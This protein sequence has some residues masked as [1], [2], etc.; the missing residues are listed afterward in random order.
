M[1]WQ[2]VAEDRKRRS[3]NTAFIVIYLDK[4]IIQNNKYSWKKIKVDKS[5][6]F[7]TLSAFISSEVI[8]VSTSLYMYYFCI[9]T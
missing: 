1:E 5:F 8:A 4:E 3:V 7:V 6:C 2:T 9:A